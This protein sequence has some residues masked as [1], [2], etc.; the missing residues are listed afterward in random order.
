MNQERSGWIGIIVFKAF[1]FTL[2]SNPGCFCNVHD[3]NEY[4]QSTK[5]I[6]TF[7]SFITICKNKNIEPLMT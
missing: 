1:F 4:F 3:K 6:E 5:V 7:P 2:A